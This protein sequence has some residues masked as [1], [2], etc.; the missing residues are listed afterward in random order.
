MSFDMVFGLT[1]VV[2]IVMFRLNIS[3]VRRFYYENESK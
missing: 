3:I 2:F 1:I